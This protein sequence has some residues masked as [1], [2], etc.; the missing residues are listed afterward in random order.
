[1]VCT[2]PYK[3]GGGLTLAKN[4]KF[5]SEIFGRKFFNSDGFP[6]ILDTCRDGSSVLSAVFV[7]FVDSRIFELF[8]PRLGAPA[9]VL[10]DNGSNCHGLAGHHIRSSSLYLQLKATARAAVGRLR[11]KIR[12]SDRKL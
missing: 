1:M 11:R 5:R 2:G 7:I 10:K 6:D 4:P 3:G 8:R 9:A 12:N